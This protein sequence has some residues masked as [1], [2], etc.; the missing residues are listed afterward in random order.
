MINDPSNILLSKLIECKSITP[1][2]NGCQ[3]I[4]LNRLPVAAAVV[5]D[6]IPAPIKTPCFQFLAS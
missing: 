5:S 6:A 3:D 1:D 2:D 4:I